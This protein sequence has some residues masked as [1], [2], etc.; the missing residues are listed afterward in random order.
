MYLS[1][2]NLKFLIFSVPYIAILSTS[3][4]SIFI[5]CFLFL[6]FFY[7]FKLLNTNYKFFIIFALTTIVSIGLLTFENSKAGSLYLFNIASGSAEDIEIDAARYDNKADIKFA[8]KS[9]Y[10][11]ATTL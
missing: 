10:S 6:G 11:L 5:I 7:T 8:L 9:I 1:S 4:A 2:R 3:K